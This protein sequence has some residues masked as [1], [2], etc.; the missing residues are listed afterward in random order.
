MRTRARQQIFADRR[1]VVFIKNAQ[2]TSQWQVD[3]ALSAC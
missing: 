2:N 1:D 3:L